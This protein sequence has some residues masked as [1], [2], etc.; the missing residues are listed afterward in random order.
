MGQRGRRSAA[1]QTVAK[2]VPIRERPAA[3]ERLP[4]AARGLWDAIVGELPADHLRASDLPLL[5]SYVRCLANVEECDAFLSAEGLLCDGKRHPAVGIRDAEL[6]S[7]RA[8]AEK[9]RLCPSSRIR[10]DSAGLR[11]PPSQ[12]RPWAWEG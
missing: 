9:L 5:E 8:L 11:R 10:A 7:A 4:E 2:P 3:P 1:S 12:S 6:K